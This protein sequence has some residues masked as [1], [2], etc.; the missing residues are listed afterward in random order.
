VDVVIALATNRLF[1]K[2]YKAAQF[3]EEEIVDRG[4]RAVFIDTNI[5]TADEGR[6]RQYFQ[7]HSMLDEFTATSTV[8]HIR[9]SLEGLFLQGRVCNTLPFG[10]EGQEIEGLKTHKGGT[11]RRVAIDP[12]E[13]DW[14]KKAFHWFLQERLSILQIAQRLNGEEAPPA[15]GQRA[16]HRPVGLRQDQEHLEQRQELHPAGAAGQAAEGAV[17][18]GLA[19]Y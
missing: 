19:D 8:G 16:L 15:A 13:A 11:A 7:I 3:V 6:W 14:V 4:K 1:R 18:R 2:A 10:Y 5:D 9:A 17:R 12:A